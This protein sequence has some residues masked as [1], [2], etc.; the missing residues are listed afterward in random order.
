MSVSI[1]KID[2]LITVEAGEYPY[3]L[4]P[5]FGG[6]TNRVALFIFQGIIVNST[7]IYVHFK[8][9]ECTCIQLNLS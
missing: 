8:T 1:L 5:K 9:A 7:D 4:T 6:V 2:R 3:L